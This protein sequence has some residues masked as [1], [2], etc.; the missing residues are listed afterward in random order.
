M[1]NSNTPTSQKIP[2]PLRLEPELYTK[3][4]K[5]VNVKQEKKRGFSIN[6]YLTNLIE[7]D[8]KGEN[9]EKK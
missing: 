5:H 4:K 1:N 2:I 9:N 3:L 6:E 7:K 8:L